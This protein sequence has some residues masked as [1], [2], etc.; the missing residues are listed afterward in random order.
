MRSD[1]PTLR[2][3]RE[4]WGTRRRVEGTGPNSAFLSPLFTRHRPAS[5]LKS[6]TWVT[7]LVHLAKLPRT[8]HYQTRLPQSAHLLLK[9]HSL[10]LQNRYS[11]HQAAI[12]RGTFSS[13]LSGEGLDEMERGELPL[14]FW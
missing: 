11:H 3:E 12:L 4:G 1:H 6:E 8:I 5:L 14:R 13:I 2:K 7:H 10:F 9:N